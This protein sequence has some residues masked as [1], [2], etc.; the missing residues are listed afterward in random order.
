LRAIEV[1]P[2]NTDQVLAL[3]YSGA[4]YRGHGEGQHWLVLDDDPGLYRAWTLRLSGQAPGF[5]LVATQGHGLRVISTDPL[6]ARPAE[7]SG[8]H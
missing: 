7:A 6:R 8:G 1:D 4:V 2:S 3:D 5:A